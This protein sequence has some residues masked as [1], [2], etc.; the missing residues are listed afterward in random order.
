MQH[1]ARS[2]NSNLGSTITAALLIGDTATIANVGDSRTYRMRNN[3]LTQ[4]TRDHSLV[5]RLVETNIISPEEVRSHPQRN[6]IYR[7]LGHKP[8]VAVDTFTVPLQRGDRL[9]LCSDGLWEMVL[10][11]DIVRIINT[12]RTPQEACDQLI[13]AANAAG[14]DDNISVIVIEME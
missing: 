3:Q 6:Q 9:I 14:G 8:E 10:D 1:Y 4:I 13:L 5:A 12:S 7:N 11:Q 2:R